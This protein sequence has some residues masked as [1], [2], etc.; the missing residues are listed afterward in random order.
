MNNKHLWRLIVDCA[1]ELTE[2]GRVPFT[3]QDLLTCVKRHDSAIKAD[4]VNPI[5][6]G[7]TDNL[8]NGASSLPGKTVLTSV[9]YG[10][11]M[12]RD[13]ENRRPVN[14][15]WS[16][17]GDSV[18]R[19]TNRA[20]PATEAEL[21]KI[22][23]VSL[24]DNLGSQYVVEPEVSRKYRL[25]TGAEMLHRSD[26]LVS[27]PREDRFVSIEI[28]YKSSNTDQFKC[29][30][31]DAM[32]MKQHY[33]KSILTIMLFAK[34]ASGGLSVNRAKTIC[35]PF[36]H[37]Y[38]EEIETFLVNWETELLKAIKPFF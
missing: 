10:K 18:R 23:V 3:R 21:Q 9:G 26:I 33:A 17:G 24:R 36:D 11:F 31:Y 6:Q 28:K 19:E 30:S 29:R 35:Y 5:I 12:L 32:H 7:L 22:L 37:F 1:N 16:Q 34:P 27:K 2:M 13:V 38:G 15:Q 4:S 14:D 20:L 8:K 25:P